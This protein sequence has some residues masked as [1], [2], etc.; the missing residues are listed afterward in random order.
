MNPTEP[1]TYRMVDLIN[2][3]HSPSN[4]IPKITSLILE[5]IVEIIERLGSLYLSIIECKR[6]IVRRCKIITAYTIT[7]VT[8]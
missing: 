7:R 6:T 1:E 2:S 8:L 3:T 4:I 5:R